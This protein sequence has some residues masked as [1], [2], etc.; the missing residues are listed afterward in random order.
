LALPLIIGMGIWA[1][2]TSYDIRNCLALVLIA[3]LIP[4]E[5]LARR[6]MKGDFAAFGRQ[7][8]LN[9]TTVAA[10][11]LVVLLLVS[12]PMAKPDRQLEARFE[13]DQFRLGV[14]TVLNEAVAR[15]LRA[16]CTVFTTTKYFMQI[17]SFQPYKSQFHF[18][19]YNQPI[20]DDGKVDDGT[21]KD[22]AMHRH[23]AMEMQREFESVEGCVAVLF[24]PSAQEAT[25][26]RFLQGYFQ[27]HQLSKVVEARQVELWS[28]S[29][30][31]R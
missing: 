5:A 7:S 10:F 23:N 17:V 26:L 31:G 13:A 2:R 21:N 20:G 9:D 25:S 27:R 1:D 24:A 15:Q 14:G 8:M 30:Q 29:P 19:Y 28:S 18:F 6:F 22:Y 3:A 12:L 4:V 16:G 11:A